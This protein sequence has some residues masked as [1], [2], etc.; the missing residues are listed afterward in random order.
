MNQIL[1]LS[2]STLCCFCNR[3]YNV[4]LNQIIIMSICHPKL[5]KSSPPLLLNM[6]LM[7]YYNVAIEL[8]ENRRMNKVPNNLIS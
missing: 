7:K 3:P 5:M 4:K 8:E 2:V 6:I 1:S